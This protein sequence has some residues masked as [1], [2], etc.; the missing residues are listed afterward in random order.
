MG[1]ADAIAIVFAGGIGSRMTN[2]AQPKQFLPVEGKPILVHTLEHF[3]KHPEVR[4]IYIATLASHVEDT[5]ELVRRFGLDKVRRVVPGGASAQGSIL[6]GMRCALED[7]TPEDAVALVHDGVRPLINQALITDNIALARSRGNAITAI[8]C[9]ETI[10]RSTDGAHTIESVTRR[11]EMHILQAPQT[12]TLGRAFRLNV[13]SEEDGL[14]GDFVDQAQL[15]THYGETMHL[16]PGF[17]GNV[18]ITTD[19]DYLQYQILA[20][21][22]HL[23]AV[24]GGTDPGAPAAA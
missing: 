21:S 11:D 4:A 17:R 18:K 16:V 20:A 10:A 23:A 24:I 5:W 2:A 15:L 3:Q 12:V 7:G 13:R 8:P 6:N 14:L 9:F 22:G 19:L 1:T